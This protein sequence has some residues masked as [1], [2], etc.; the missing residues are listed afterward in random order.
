MVMG[1]IHVVLSVHRSIE[2]MSG[3]TMHNS[4]SH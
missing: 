3:I 4:E 2:L 1:H